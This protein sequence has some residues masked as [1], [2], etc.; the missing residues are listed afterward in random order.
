MDKKDWMKKGKK[1]KQD[2][3]Q[4][5]KEERRGQEE[6]ENAQGIKER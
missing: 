2:T 3:G 1:K 5:R 4:E 6:P